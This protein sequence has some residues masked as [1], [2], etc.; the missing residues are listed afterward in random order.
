VNPEAQGDGV[1]EALSS[2]VC[3]EYLELPGLSV[4]FRQAQRL[5]SLDEE[6]CL[7]LLQWLIDTGFLYRESNAT[8]SVVLFRRTTAGSVSRPAA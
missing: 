7:R 2:R 4:T 1:T 6:T 3:D 8:G 5:W